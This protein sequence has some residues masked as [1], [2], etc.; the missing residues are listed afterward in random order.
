MLFAAFKSEL[1]DEARGL[2]LNGLFNLTSPE[3]LIG[4]FVGG[5]M[6]FLFAALSMEAVGRAGGQVVEE[7]REPVPREPRDHGGDRAT[8][9]RAAVGIVTAAAHQGDDPARR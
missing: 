2:D 7:V 8:R 5:M 6:L 4:L 3:V 9:L 1:A